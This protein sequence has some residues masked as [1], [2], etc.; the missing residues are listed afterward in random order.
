M[1]PHRAP[2]GRTLSGVAGKGGSADVSSALL[3]L[4]RMRNPTRRVAAA[5][6]LLER[7]AAL[8]RE[9]SRIRDDALCR[10]REDGE[11][12]GAIASASGLTRSRIV[13]LLRRTDQISGS[14]HAADR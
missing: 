12:Y 11:S 10:L 7:L 13:Q 6:D 2:D 8:E 5:T 3:A 4:R 1:R 14:T 9:V